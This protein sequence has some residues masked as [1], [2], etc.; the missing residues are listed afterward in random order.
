MLLNGFAFRAHT[1]ACEHFLA[2]NLVLGNQ[3]RKSI[4]DTV[5]LIQEAFNSMLVKTIKLMG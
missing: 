1:S 2:G 4:I 5:P 3:R